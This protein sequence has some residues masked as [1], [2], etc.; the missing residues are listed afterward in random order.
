MSPDSSARLLEI[1]ATAPAASLDLDVVRCVSKLAFDSGTPPSYLYCSENRN[2]LNPA[3]VASLYFADTHAT[4]Q[5]E[6]EAQWTGTGRALEPVVFFHAHVRLAAVLDLLDGATRELFGVTDD[7]LF[8]AWLVQ[9]APTRLER[10]AHAIARQSRVSA[11]RY[12]SAACRRAGRDGWNL[13]VYRSTL[14]SPDRLE[15]LGRDRSVLEAIP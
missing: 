2:R 7:D 1:L 13:A 6:F 3:G 14:R 15:I 11:V 10:L 9:P 12:P 5:V 8:G 4:V